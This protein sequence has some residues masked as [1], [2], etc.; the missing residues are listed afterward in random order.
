MP[1]DTVLSGVNGTYVFASQTPNDLSKGLLKS[2][3]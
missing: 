2:R 1:P 3:A